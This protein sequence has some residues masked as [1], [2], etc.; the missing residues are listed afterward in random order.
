MVGVVLGTRVGEPPPGMRAILSIVDTEPAVPP[1]LL[2]FLRDLAHYYL[3]PIGEVMRLAL[4]PVDKET[5]KSLAAPSLFGPVAR[6]VATKRVLWVA[7]TSNVEHGMKLGSQASAILAQLRAAGDAPLARLEEKWGNA[8][9]AV[10]R[11]TELGLCTVDEREAPA[12]PFFAEPAPRDALPELTAPQAAASSV[13]AESLASHTPATFLLHGV[14]GSGKTEVYLRAIA[15]ARQAKRGTV[16]LVPEIALTPQLV[17]RFRARFGDEVAVLHSGLSPRE[18]HAMWRRLRAGEVDVA[19]GARS[20]L[21]AP[22]R[23]LGLVVVDEEHDPSF[24]QE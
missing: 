9:A 11:L 23:A 14:T 4:P 22:V 13:I 16:V 8:R 12:D 24:K 2:A 6:G 10:K 17:A 3:A 7:P 15:A 21:F 19:I 18:R 1:D 20:A 5:A